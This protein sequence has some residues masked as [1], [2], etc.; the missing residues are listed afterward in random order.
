MEGDWK[1]QKEDGSVEKCVYVWEVLVVGKSILIDM[2]YE[3]LHEGDGDGTCGERRI[4]I[5]EF[6]GMSH[7]WV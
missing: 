1:G 3:G 6:M 2:L 5:R 4:H 7:W